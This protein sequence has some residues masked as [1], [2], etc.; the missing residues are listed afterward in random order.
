MK[1]LGAKNSKLILV[2]FAFLF[3]VMIGGVAYAED[4][5]I[6]LSTSDE[7]HLSMLPGTINLAFGTITAE[8]NNITGYTI[9]PTITG[10]E[11]LYSAQLGE[12]LPV[13]TSTKYFKDMHNEYGFSLDAVRFRP[14]SRFPEETFVTK[15]RNREG[16]NQYTLVLG[17]NIDMEMNVGE[18]T[19][20]IQFAMIANN[21]PTCVPEAICYFGN[22][23]DVI[24]DE[25]IQAATSGEKATLAAPNFSRPGYAFVGWNTREDGRGTM[26]GPNQTIDVDDITDYG[27]SLHA[28]WRQSDGIM[29]NWTGCANLSKN[30]VVALT[31]MRDN[32]TYLVAKL[33]DNKCW[34]VENLRLA[35]NAANISANN[36]NGPTS[37][38]ISEARASVPSN[39]LCNGNNAACLDI[40]QYNLS[41]INSAL[42]PAYE[43]NIAGQPASW[44]GYGGYYNWYT[45]TAGN[46][47]YAMDSGSTTG[48]ICPAG[49][50]LPT[51]GE[52][53]DGNQLNTAINSGKTN[54]DE[55][56]R[57]YPNNFVYSGDYNRNTTGGRSTYARYWTSTAS[58]ANNAY[59]LGLTS[60]SVTL[61]SN[62]YNKWAA[63]AIRC[64]AGEGASAIGNI[65]YDANGGEGLI[66]DDTNVQLYS[67]IIK[68]NIFT[69]DGGVFHGWNTAADGSGLYV[70]AGDIATNTI[71]A[72]GLTDGDTLNLYAIWGINI[73]LSFETT[74]SEATVAPITKSTI[75][76]SVT[77][78]IPANEPT[79]SEHEFVG[80]SL[81]PNA[82]EATYH[83]Y[84]EITIT[85][86]QTLYAVYGPENCPAKKVC[87]RG[88]GATEGAM[89][90]HNVNS[91]A[92]VTLGG[93]DFARPGYGFAGYNTV[94]DG[95]GTNYGP[96]QSFT[97]GDVSASG[98]NL[99][100]QWVA[101]VGDMQGFT[102]CASM[103]NG[104]V[105][106]LTDTRDGNT[107]AVAKLADGKCWMIENMR[108]DPVNATIT[109]E[110]TNN[111]NSTF[112]SNLASLSAP[113]AACNADADAACVDRI[114][115]NTNNINRENSPSSSVVNAPASWY[116]YGVYYNW[117]TATAGNGTYSMTSGN[118]TGDLCPSGW[119]LPTAD[120]SGDFKT[121]NSVANNND[122]NTDPGYRTYPANFVYSGDIGVT[123]AGRGSNGRYWSAT[124]KD[125]KN[126][127]RLGIPNK[128][129]SEYR[130]WDGFAIRCIAN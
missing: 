96:Q 45:A 53:G 6:T 90:S 102:G 56:F 1:Y 127:Y 4:P 26:Y 124:A 109:A 93:S 122:N 11:D 113:E 38:F 14:L 2:F 118:V 99:Y 86:N 80:W 9:I 43:T 128:R 30:Q 12:Y 126:A 41:N 73:T 17:A 23:T 10:S 92:T 112:L 85:D 3:S 129:L 130:K 28:I 16:A 68:Q 78:E 65:H 25:F 114:F 111:P 70:E 89:F 63:F 40:L 75:T 35:P 123:I 57:K 108:L 67:T 51:G 54:N 18:Y 47:T 79:Y 34:Q 58:S 76:G 104:D 32:N 42:D 13:V 5:T 72:L 110:N 121:Y 19:N 7:I 62:N 36:T 66:A 77:I 116:S 98:V 44:Y 74:P 8:T 117:Y 71:R 120:N 107:Y 69:K 27:I 46:G 39:T 61:K 106:A 87:Y 115:Y 59:R 37:S 60:G 97:T 84:D 48:D 105:T 49:W 94:E 22:G 24:G 21:P 91:N 95:S 119:H 100:A 20:E 55:N 103:S 88:N 101:S 15:H 125:N 64:I 83:P 82:T 33:G 81:D 31:D 52:D 50:R 29:Q